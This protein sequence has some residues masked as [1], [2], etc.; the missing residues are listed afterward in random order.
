MNR[1]N[2]SKDEQDVT[3]DDSDG[4][5]YNTKRIVMPDG[6]A[7]VL[8][9]NKNTAQGLSRGVTNIG[10]LA[11]TTSAVFEDNLAQVPN[12][13]NGEIDSDSFVASPNN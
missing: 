3:D 2:L 10:S 1:L 9:E 11:N 12:V 5:Q 13:V 4:T 7:I 8:K 6:S